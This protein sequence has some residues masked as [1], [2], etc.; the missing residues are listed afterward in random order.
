MLESYKASSKS[1]LTSRASK[2][3]F[4]LSGRLNFSFVFLAMFGDIREFVS[5][6]NLSG[7]DCFA[8]NDLHQVVRYSVADGIMQSSL[9]RRHL[10][11]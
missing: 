11:N 3:D 10:K 1:H 5:L 4:G 7:P 2:F 8:Q 9:G 6:W